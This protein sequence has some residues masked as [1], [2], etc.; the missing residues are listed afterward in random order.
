MIK[1]EFDGPTYYNVVEFRHTDQSFVLHGIYTSSQ[2][3]QEHIDALRQDLDYEESDF[4][5]RS[6][7]LNP[8]RYPH[9]GPVCSMIIENN[10]IVHS[11]LHHMIY[12][13]ADAKNYTAN[14]TDDEDF[15]VVMVYGDWDDAYKFLD[16]QGI[17]YGEG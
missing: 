8:Y 16:E 2:K 1:V 14:P 3:A 7:P 15:T 5:W 17:S 13:L 6:T 10:T 11:A 12:D 4:F 9:Y